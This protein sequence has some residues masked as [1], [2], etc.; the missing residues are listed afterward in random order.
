MQYLDLPAFAYAPHVVRSQQFNPGDL[1]HL[2]RL[3]EEI[4][5]RPDFFSSVLADIEVAILFWEQSSRTRTSFQKA[6]QMLGANPLVVED[7]T[8]FSSAAKGESLADS[9]RQYLAQGYRYLIIRHKDEGSVEQAAGVAGPGNPVINAGDG[10]GQHPTQTLLD[11]YTIWKEF[12]TLERPLIVGVLGDLLR[13]RTVHSLVYLLG[14]FRRVQF[15]FI[16]PPDSRM[17]PDLLEHLDRHYVPYVEHTAG[18]LRKVVRDLDV[19]YVTRP[20]TERAKD[21]DEKATLIAQYQSFIVT[22]EVANAMPKHGIIFHPLPRTFEIPTEV[23]KNPRARY[24]QQ[25]EN[26]RFVRAGLLTWIKY[27]MTA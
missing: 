11:L 6:C 25:M 24:F 7:M 5:K 1:D 3:V 9:V 20:Q 18:D 8:K 17:K 14:K 15:V 10:K 23:D 21:D 12:G 22:D 19:L 13:G 4:R 2:F 16:S 26:G 27:L